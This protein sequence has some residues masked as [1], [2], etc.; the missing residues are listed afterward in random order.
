MNIHDQDIIR[1]A[2]REASLEKA[3]EDAVM[4]IKDYSETPEIAAKKMNAPLELV[5]EALST[6]N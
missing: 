1:I 2:K 3:V 4:L 6:N 5:L